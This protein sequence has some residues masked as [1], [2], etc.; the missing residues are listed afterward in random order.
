MEKRE[1]VAGMIKAYQNGMK[2]GLMQGTVAIG[3]TY[4]GL[5]VIRKLLEIKPKNK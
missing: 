4:A 2:D 5:T 3:L 1:I